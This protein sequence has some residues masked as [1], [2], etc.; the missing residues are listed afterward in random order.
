MTAI[1][2]DN[3]EA[4]AHTLCTSIKKMNHDVQIIN[5]FNDLKMF[6]EFFNKNSIQ[7]DVIF[8]DIYFGNV[9]I[10]EKIDMTKLTKNIIIT[11]QNKDFAPKAFRL[12]AIDFL[13]KPIHINHLLESIQ[14]VEKMLTFVD[15]PQFSKYKS[16]F[17]VSMGKQIINIKIEEIDYIESSNKMTYIHLIYGKKIPSIIPLIDLENML[18]PKIFIRANRQ[19]IFHFDAIQT[20]EKTKSSRYLVKL[21]HC[22]GKTISL[23]EKKSKIF[24]KWMDR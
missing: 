22:E 4:D 1:I 9:N 12:N 6:T 11:T 19:V 5:Q 16:H 24:R 3:N 8:T 23:S 10:F 18:D 13:L 17:Q 2:L 20:I 21:K 14:K 7:V 15:E